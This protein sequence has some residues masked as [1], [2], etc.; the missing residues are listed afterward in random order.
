MRRTSIFSFLKQNED[1]SLCVILAVMIKCTLGLAR[2][3]RGVSGGILPVCIANYMLSLRLDVTYIPLDSE[4]I[5]E[6]V[7]F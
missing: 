6:N 3:R 7:T 1:F 5:V 4:S 2:R